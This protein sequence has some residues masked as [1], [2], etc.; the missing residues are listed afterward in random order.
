VASKD[1]TVSDKLLRSCSDDFVWPL[2]YS[3]AYGKFLVE[4]EFHD[5]KVASSPG[6]EPHSIWTSEEYIQSQ[7]QL[8][9]SRCLSRMLEEGIHTDV[10]IF[11]ASGSIGAHRAIL[12]ARSPVFDSM[13]SHN[14]SEKQSATVHI[15]DMALEPCRALLS[16]LY[17]NLKYQDFRK[18]RIALVRASHKYDIGDLKEACEASLVDDIDGS[19]VLARLQDAWLYQLKHLKREC[20]RYLLEFGKIHDLREEFDAFLQEID[21]DLVVELVQE[22]M[23]LLKIH[24]L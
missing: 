10:T 5:L 12:A 23:K 16:Y 3:V 4:V 21:K 7:A 8:G 22:Q 15:N 17:G 1:L 20:L 13:F 2:D 6:G 9:L 14:L 19:N 24:G 18:H 11:T